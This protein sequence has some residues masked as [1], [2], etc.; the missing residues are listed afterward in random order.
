M[1]TCVNVLCSLSLFKFRS[2][3]KLNTGKTGNKFSFEKKAKT[4]AEY[5]EKQKKLNQSQHHTNERFEMVR[6]HIRIS[7]VYE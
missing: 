1:V 4:T 7:L 2:I 6:L 3:D 5:R